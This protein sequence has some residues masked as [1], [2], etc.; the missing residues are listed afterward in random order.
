MAINWAAFGKA[1]MKSWPE[2]GLDGFELQELA[3]RHQVIKPYKNGF[4][5]S[6]H[7]DGF[8]VCAERGDAWF[9]RNYRVTPP[10]QQEG[11]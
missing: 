6:L 4:D 10:A 3:E 11:K 1:V 5:P 9:Y 2:G 7:S 8:G